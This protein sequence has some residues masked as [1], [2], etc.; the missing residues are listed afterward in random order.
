MKFLTTGLFG[1]LVCF[2]FGIQV[3]SAANVSVSDDGAVLV[4]PSDLSAY[5]LSTDSA[6]DNVTI[7]NTDFV[8]TIPAGSSVT[9]TSLD[10]SRN[11]DNSYSST[12][13]DSRPERSSVTISNPSDAVSSITATITPGS[14]CT[15]TATVAPTHVYG[16]GSSGGSG[17]GNYHAVVPTV[18]PTT[19]TTSTSVSTASF[20]RDMSLNAKGND[21]KMLQVFLNS[22]GFTIAKTGAGSQGNETTTFGNMTRAALIKFQKTYGIT[23]AAGYFGPITRNFVQII[24]NMQN[25]LSH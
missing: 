7:E 22:H 11:L 15:A 20:V 8:F 21:V 18:V 13:C 4:L 25:S 3:V 14:A 5:G 12:V 6:F 2:L 19:N 17:G 9:L 24:Q 23:P 1:L 10:S 16:G